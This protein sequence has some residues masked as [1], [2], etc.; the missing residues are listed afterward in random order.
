MQDLVRGSED[1]EGNTHT[2]THTQGYVYTGSCKHTIYTHIYTQG[3]SHRQ[4]HMHCHVKK[5]CTDVN[6]NPYT[7]N[8]TPWKG[9]VVQWVTA[10]APQPAWSNGSTTSQLGNLGKLLNYSLPEFPHFKMRK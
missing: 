4:T 3:H 7:Y 10:Q 5:S 1:S 6:M 8:A 9:S 2:H